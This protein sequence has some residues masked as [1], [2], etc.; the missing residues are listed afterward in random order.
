MKKLP[1]I[2]LLAF[3]LL[4]AASC[5]KAPIPNETLPAKTEERPAGSAPVSALPKPDEHT[6]QALRSDRIDLFFP[7]SGHDLLTTGKGKTE[8]DFENACKVYE[9]LGYTLYSSMETGGNLAKTYIKNEALAHLYYHPSVKELNVV[10]SDNLGANLPPA[11]PKETRGD[12]E[13]TVTQLNQVKYGSGGMG[14]VIRLKD[15]SFIIYDGGLTSSADE[16]LAILGES[17]PEGKP[18]VRAWILTHFHNDHY[19]AFYEIARRMQEEELLTLEYVIASPIVEGYRK[20]LSGFADRFF[21]F[22]DAKFIFA[23]TGM[24][25]T[26]CN[27]TLEILYTPESLYKT[28]KPVENFNNTSMLTRL[29]DGENSMLF[30]GDLALE[31]ASLCEALYGDALASTWCQMSHHGLED[32][33]LSFYERVKASVYFVPTT[34]AVYRGERNLALR[35]AVEELPTTKEILI[36]GEALY[37][38]PFRNN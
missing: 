38:R 28:G 7:C 1:I 22:G 30:T 32:C 17:C 31:G 4:C 12:F 16:I 29:R 37:T 11:T 36:A 27:L 35:R 9:K 18:L 25:F 3:L 6:F 34:P 14:Y 26:F 24:K 2:F 33:P 8:A 15:G 10:V 19:E 5:E 13:C 20:F 23:H 21:A